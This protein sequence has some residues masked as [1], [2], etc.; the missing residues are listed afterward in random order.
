MRDLVLDRVRSALGERPF[1]FFESIGSTNDIALE[2]LRDKPVAGAVVLADEQ[3]EGRGRMGRKWHTPPGQALAVSYILYPEVAFMNRIGMLGA[4]AVARLLE[5]LKVDNVGIKWPN[6]VYVGSRKICG[7]LPQAAWESPRL[8]G[9]VLGIGLNI[10]VQFDETLALTALN[11]EDILEHSIDRV[12]M[13]KDLLDLLDEGMRQLHTDAWFAD[14]RRRLIL[15]GRV[16]R[17]G[18]VEGVAQD[19]DGDGAL[20]V[21]LSDGSM[22]RILAGD[23]LLIPSGDQRG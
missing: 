19:V 13:L 23:V 12:L 4:W 3:T 6:D 21:R 18:D 7:V 20:L 16:V 8:L 17:V 10:R 15:L 9:V 2:W 1:R 11:L 14:W 5:A 22:Q